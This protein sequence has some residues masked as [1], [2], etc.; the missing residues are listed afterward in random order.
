MVRLSH[1]VCR[2]LM[3]N[4]KYS[5]S[6]HIHYVYNS[7]QSEI[8]VKFCKSFSQFLIILKVY[9]VVYLFYILCRERP[10]YFLAQRTIYIVSTDGQMCQ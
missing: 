5:W 3:Y 2:I 4:K 6:Q 7:N 10:R 9:I 8:I 1:A